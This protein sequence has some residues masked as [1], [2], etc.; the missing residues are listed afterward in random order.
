MT[1]RGPLHV[2]GEVLATR[3]AGAFR[4]L[5]LAAPGVP[6]RHRPGT[7]VAVSVAGEHLARRPLWIHRVRETGAF[8]PT[9]D[10]VVEAV[11]SGTRWLADRPVGAR[12][13]VTGPLGRPFALPR[14][15]VACLLVGEGYAA[16]PLFV[17]AERLRERSCAVDLV[18]AGRDEE[19]VFSAL[20]A[21]RLARSVKVFTADGSLGTRGGVGGHVESVLARGDAAVVYAAG[22]LGTLQEVSRAAERHG[23]SSQLALEVPMPCGTGLCHGCRVVLRDEHGDGREAR[24]CTEGPVVRGDRVDWEALG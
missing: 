12:V 11:G 9:I 8:G 10:V 13:E 17:L 24:A 7:F 16:A 1:D 3:R 15:P 4:V 5:T 20:E 19:H 2:T 18:V 22:P 14:E 23:V 21:R 6:Q